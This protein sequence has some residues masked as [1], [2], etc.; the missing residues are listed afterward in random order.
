MS[1]KKKEKDPDWG[2]ADAAL[3]R[4]LAKVVRGERM[5]AIFSSGPGQAVG[6]EGAARLA[7]ALWERQ[8]DELTQG[9]IS[10]RLQGN[11]VGDAGTRCL[12]EALAE[13]Q[14]RQLRTLDLS[15]NKITAAG[16][17]ELAKALKKGKCLQQLDLSGNSIG[18]QGAQ[19][20]AQALPSHHDIAELDLSG[21]AIGAAGAQ[22]LRAE[23][24][25]HKGFQ[26]IAL[27]RNPLGDAGAAHLAKIFGKRCGLTCVSLISVNLGDAGA[28]AL[29]KGML[30]QPGLR[31]LW[32]GS[33]R[34]E[35]AGALSLAQAME[36]HGGLR[37]LSLE[38]NKIT[39]KG[40]MDCV[41]VVVRLCKEELRGLQEITVNMSGNSTRR[42]SE[43]TLNNLAVAARTARLISKRCI[44]LEAMLK[45]WK[46]YTGVGKIDED[47]HTTA[48]VVKNVIIPET[49]A[50]GACYAEFY[51]CF[52]P[53]FYVV[54]SWQALFGD[55]LRAL[56]THASG[57]TLPNLD[58]FHEQYTRR[59][60]ALTVRYFV[61]V[62]CVDQVR[63]FPEGDP[64]C[65]TD[66]FDFIMHE[67]KRQD[68]KVLVAMDRDYV[69]L[70]RIWCLAEVYYAKQFDMPLLISFGPIRPMPR[71]RKAL[72]INDMATSLDVDKTLLVEELTLRGPGTGEKFED[73][74]VTP[75]QKQATATYKE[76]YSNMPS[77]QQYECDWYKAQDDAREDMKRYAAEGKADK[78][79]EAVEAGIESRVEESTMA[80][81]RTRLSQLELIL[82]VDAEEVPL[83]T[84]IAEMQR[85]LKAARDEKLDDPDLI[86]RGQEKL[87]ILLAEARRQEAQTALLAATRQG[88]SLVKQWEG[89]ERRIRQGVAQPLQEVAKTIVAN[90][91]RN[92]KEMTEKELKEEEKQ[93][94]RTQEENNI[95]RT[96]RLAVEEGSDAGCDAEPLQKGWKTFAELKVFSAVKARLLRLAEEEA[97]IAAAEAARIEALCAA[98]M[99]AKREARAANAAAKA[100]ERAARIESGE[101]VSSE[102][103]DDD[104]D[105]DDMPEKKVVEDEEQEGREAEQEDHA[106]VEN[107][108]VDSLVD[109][110]RRGRETGARDEIRDFGKNWL[111]KLD[112][113]A[114]LD[115]IRA[116]V[117]YFVSQRSAADLIR[118]I[119]QAVEAGLDDKT[120]LKASAAPGGG[121]ALS[122]RPGVRRFLPCVGAEQ[123]AEIEPG[124]GDLPAEPTGEAAKGGELPEEAGEPGDSTAEH[125]LEDEPSDAERQAEADIAALVHARTRHAC[126][127][128]CDAIEARDLEKLLEAVP[129]AE[130]LNVDASETT[131]GW[132][133]IR[134][135]ELEVAVKQQDT[136]SMRKCLEIAREVHVDDEVVREAARSLARLEIKQGMDTSNAKLLGR[137]LDEGEAAGMTE[138]QLYQGKNK[139]VQ[140]EVSR[141]STSESI[142]DLRRVIELA[143]DVGMPAS[144]KELG[145]VHYRLM[146]LEL[147]EAIEG[148]SIGVLKKCI[149]AAKA[150]TERPLDDLKKAEFRLCVLELEDAVREGFDGER[151]TAAMWDAK[152]LGVPKE[153][154][155]QGKVKL[156]ELS[157]RAFTDWVT[158][159]IQEAVQS[160]EAEAPPGPLRKIIDEAKQADVDPEDIKPA[161][162]KLCFLELFEVLS[163]QQIDKVE[164]LLAKSAAFDF[165]KSNLSSERVRL[166]EVQDHLA[167]L[168]H[169]KKA[170][171]CEDTLRLAMMTND[172]V[173]LNLAIDEAQMLELDPELIK[174]AKEKLADFS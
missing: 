149:D 9:I 104:S 41:G 88:V 8:G 131:L 75:F 78:L 97:A 143:A 61:D 14:L 144:N 139:Y 87:D 81:H 107:G 117:A 5:V 153:M 127:V 100:A 57:F 25:N 110:L 15:G 36:E 69:P 58:P 1:P 92:P 128:M 137:A 47:G 63:K 124:E 73:T 95:I 48:D 51:H 19:S 158:E 49:E 113:D 37:V 112:H 155:V 135:L 134:E 136:K 154:F 68:V 16:C 145:V 142:P 123:P 148:S 168:E 126:L 53:E 118:I 4:T 174:A 94:E 169:L 121:Y 114:F 23:M 161:E 138:K 56:A 166:K 109:A 93:K 67:M 71:R 27:S 50:Y 20:I 7:E 105:D 54:H 91:G 151:L 152:A 160:C 39:D 70:T 164:D 3:S 83:M 172:I 116:E 40:V 24:A 29:A 157:S 59:P 147:R 18:D 65:E 163:S 43:S 156:A 34:V 80:P 44:K 46:E 42:F 86:R 45:F 162:R 101:D 141:A 72:T 79:R 6:D 133:M 122:E 167:R 22:A 30:E 130:R 33:N 52:L 89:D 125:V 119:G 173:T 17:K 106:D 2:T 111:R 38:R 77:E 84:D 82:A 132:R 13:G 32:L 115:S 21:N 74:V 76:I 103:E 159:E 165:N 85:T 90:R 140:L 31:E 98:E 28:T 55:L 129:E 12:A 60:E 35:D 64:R 120:K 11:E 108:T 96:L 26:K 66:K 102:E 171:E 150:E 146:L 170:R 10:L 62:F 99:Q